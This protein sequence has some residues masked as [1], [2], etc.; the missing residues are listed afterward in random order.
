MIALVGILST[1]LLISVLAQKL[2]FIRSERY[3]HNFMLQIGLLEEQKNQAANVIKFA[4]KLYVLR[5]KDPTNW[6]QHIRIER[7]LLRSVHFS[8]RLKE[9]QRKLVDACVDLPELFALQR[10]LSTKPKDEGQQLETMELK[11]D[12]IAAELAKVNESIMDVKKTL[13][14]LLHKLP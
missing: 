12:R 3:A 6:S 14:L 7:R 13:D 2:Q 8:K 9:E 1:A 10:E 11:V 5:Q 4:I